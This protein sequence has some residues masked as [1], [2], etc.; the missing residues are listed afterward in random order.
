MCEWRVRHEAQAL[1]SPL[2]HPFLATNLTYLPTLVFDKDEE[3][4]PAQGHLH[5]DL[6]QS[7]HQGPA[8]HLPAAC[9]VSWWRISWLCWEGGYGM[10]ITAWKPWSG[11]GEN[12]RLWQAL[13][14]G[15]ATTNQRIRD[16][17]GWTQMLGQIISG[18]A[19]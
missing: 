5:T 6:G 19:F 13:G 15:I 17:C 14:V 16:G 4:A 11:M 10:A 1:Q 3:T 9:Q 2:N 7:Q 8:F 18:A 12:S